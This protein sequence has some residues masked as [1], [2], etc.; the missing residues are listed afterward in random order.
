MSEYRTQ[1]ELKPT[2]D[3]MARELFDEDKLANVLDF[4]EFLKNNQLTPRWYTTNS[5]S[6]KYK[7]KTVCT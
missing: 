4:L 3:D 2:V 5:W 6:V 7:N 1:K